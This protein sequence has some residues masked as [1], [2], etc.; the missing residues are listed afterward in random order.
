MFMG[1]NS[2]IRGPQAPQ[3]VP[4]IASAPLVSREANDSEGMCAHADI[5]LIYFACVEILSQW[6]RRCLVLKTPNVWNGYPPPD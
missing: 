5:S 1:Q 4:H 6:C 2:T 3:E